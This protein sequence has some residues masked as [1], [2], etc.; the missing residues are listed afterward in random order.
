MTRPSRRPMPAALLA[1]VLACAVVAARGV[2][3]PV[4]PANEAEQKAALEEARKAAQPGPA[5]LGLGDQAK[6]NLP[7]GFVYVPPQPGGRLMRAMGNS[8]GN[9]FEGLVV[10]LLKDGSFSFYDVKYEASG[11][12][13]DDDAKSWDA[14][15]LI[16]RIREATTAGNEE[17][18]RQG[19]AG[20]EV[21]GW[22]EPPRYQADTHQLV[23]SI[24]L[25]QIGAPADSSTLLNYRTLVL[26]RE[27]YVAMTLVT[28]EAHIDALRPVTATLLDALEFNPGKRYADFNSGTDH[29]A[30][31]GL[32]ALVAGVAAKKLGLLALGAAFLVK[33]AKVI[34][35]AV[36]G[37]VWWLRRRLGLAARKPA[38]MAATAIV[39]PAPAEAGPNP[40]TAA[41][42]RESGPNP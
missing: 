22:I 26:G 23:W 20:L 40:G 13:K 31:I 6:L 35:V 33:F 25:R 38:P 10:P 14:D 29:V 11:Y 2:D 42:K 16:K 39:P 5:E 28:D 9:G 36:I 19:V 12:V 32:A 30:E 17:R 8:V 34:G 1:A 41:E 4:P 7:Q 37:A 15:D 18:R 24:G 21:T 27:G 3:E